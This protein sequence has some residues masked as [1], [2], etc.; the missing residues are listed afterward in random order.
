MLSTFQD[1]V[2]GLLLRQLEPYDFVLSGGYALNELA[3]THRPTRDIDL[4]TNLLDPAEFSKAVDDAVAALE[5]AGYQVRVTRK[6]SMFARIDIQDETQ[7][8]EVDLGYDYREFEPA[9]R[10][11]GPVLNDKDAILNK[12]SALYARWLP[13]DFIDLFHIRKSG[14]LTDGEIL[15]YSHERDEGFVREYFIDALRKVQSQSYDSFSEYGI[16]RTDYDEIKSAA[17]NW[18]NEIESE[19]IDS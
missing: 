18:A 13:R 16:T 10:E 14:I 4:F 8:V 2:A 1:S 7:S 12:I 11:I 5:N 6:T 15:K 19:F 9:I 17:L 3:L